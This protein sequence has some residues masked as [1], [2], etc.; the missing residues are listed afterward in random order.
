MTLDHVIPKS[1]GVDNSWENLVC[2]CSDCN[3]K[4]GDRTPEEAGMSL[5]NIPKKPT[6]MI[7]ECRHQKQYDLFKMFLDEKV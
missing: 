6:N 3:S 7:I 1:K 5:L 2:C 4:K